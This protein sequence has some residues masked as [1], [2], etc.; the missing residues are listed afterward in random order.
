LSENGEAVVCGRTD[1]EEQPQGW[2]YVKNAED[3]RPIFAVEKEREYFFPSSYP[4]KTHQKS[5]ASKT[6]PPSSESIELAFL[7]KLPIDHPKAKTNQVPQWLI[8]KGIPAHATETR[9]YYSNNQWIS[10][11]EW[12]DPDRSKGH[13]KTIRQCHRKPNGKVKWSKGDRS[14]LPPRIEEA[15]AKRAGGNLAQGTGKWILG[16]EGESCVEAA[17]SLGL[18]AI[19]WQGSAWSEEELTAGLTELKQSGVA[20]LVY[21][22]D[23][24]EPGRK[25]A[26]LVVSAA[27]SLQFPLLIIEPL[28]LWQEMPHKGDLVDWIAWGK[29]QGLLSKDLIQ[30]L[31]QAIKKNC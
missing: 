1:A 22:P 4:I 5:K 7:L 13:D 14:W 27:Q 3:E 18:V 10:R 28:A 29:K 20:G 2:R 6:I 12:Q 19:T 17:R 15:F 24:D 31:E 11:F 16:V 23:N 25:K 30:G 21:L 9:Y 26:E 8:E